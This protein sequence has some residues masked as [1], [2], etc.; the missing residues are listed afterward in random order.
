[1]ALDFPETPAMPRRLGAFPLSGIALLVGLL[2]H[3]GDAS[4]Q[5]TSTPEFLQIST[6]SGSRGGALVSSINSDPRTFNRLLAH[7]LHS[8]IVAELISADL[9]HVDRAT[10]KLEPALASRWDTSADGRTFTLH[11]RRGLRFS[12][13][14]PMTADDVLFSLQLAQDPKVPTWA[15]DLL[16]VDGT[17]PTVARVDSHTVRITFPRATGTGLRVLDSLAILPKHRLESAYREGK[18][19]SAW[20]PAT[21]PADLAGMG[22]FRVR[23]F[24][25]GVKL[26][27]ERNPHYWR[28]DK[29]GQILPYVDSLTLLVIPDRGAEA[30]RFQTGETD[31]LNSLDPESFTGLKRAE[32]RGGFK[33][34]DVGPALDYDFLSFNLNPG[35]NAAGKPYVDAEKRAL[36]EKTAFRRAISHAINRP[37]IARSVLLGLGAPQYGPVSPGNREWYRPPSSPPDFNPA[38]AREILAS[39]GLKDGDKNGTLDLAP[40][41]DLEIT[42]LT[43]RGYQRRERTAEILRDDLSKV[44]IRLLTQAIDVR[45]LVQRITTS[46]DYELFLFGFTPTDPEP[47]SLT[48]VWLSS[49]TNHFWHPSQARPARPWESEMDTLI[50]RLVRSTVDGERKKLFAQFQE[51]WV[52]EMPTIPTVSRN[53]LCAWK[54][55]VTNVRPSVRMPHLTWNAE[56]LSLAPR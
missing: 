28:K 40:G 13:G 25:P 22:P 55:R 17:F 35:K 48:D 36:F 7:D 20:S 16:R 6:L 51:I 11:L 14:A 4:T 30:L 18:L 50:S 23:Q 26:V 53:I 27:F 44:G 43:T 49:G 56:E 15:G 39:L 46:F 37:G 34:H 9:V 21:N 32:T 3:A 5:E 33:V 2:L 19:G 29:A 31:V 38:R 10:L 41:K 52:K 8:S 12:D 54:T 1:M 42:L 47:D 45:E 24:Q